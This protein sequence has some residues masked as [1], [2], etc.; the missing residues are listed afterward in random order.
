MISYIKK[1]AWYGS[2]VVG[3]GQ[4]HVQHREEPPF[5]VV[6][7]YLLRDRNPEDPS[8]LTRSVFDQS[9]ETS[10]DERILLIPGRLAVIGLYYQEE[11]GR[12]RADNSI[13]YGP[14]TTTHI[15]RAYLNGKLKRYRIH[16]VE[17]IDQFE[18]D[19][20]EAIVQYEISD[21][22][23]IVNQLMP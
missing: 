19:L 3:G 14:S 4:S 10:E 9:S 13:I 17:D 7:A 12:L 22:E 11:D 5:T 20:R 18:H 15:L 8:G 2:A 23:N 1:Y 6:E 21:I 16:R